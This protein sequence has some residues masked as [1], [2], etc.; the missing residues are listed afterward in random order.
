MNKIV[1]FLALCAA[2]T[3]SAQENQSGYSYGG[4]EDGGGF[5]HGAY[6]S[7]VTWQE[8]GSPGFRVYNDSNGRHCQT[9]GSGT[10]RHTNCD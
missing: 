1:L 6:D 2:T 7:G 4:D 5:R 3:A 8:Y 9:F 10:Y